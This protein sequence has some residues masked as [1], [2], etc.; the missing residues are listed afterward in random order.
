MALDQLVQFLG[1]EERRLMDLVPALAVHI[2]NWLSNNLTVAS[3]RP[4]HPNKK[5]NRHT[6]GSLKPAIHD[7]GRQV[8]LDYC[9]AVFIKD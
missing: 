3:Q 6:N 9:P 5:T 4:Q 1:D 7:A 2:L 8:F